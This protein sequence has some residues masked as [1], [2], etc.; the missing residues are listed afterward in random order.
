MA[1]RKL[2]GKALCGGHRYCHDEE[3]L[4]A[5]IIQKNDPK[6]HKKRAFLP[7]FEGNRLSNCLTKD[8]L[9]FTN[10]TMEN[11]NDNDRLMHLKTS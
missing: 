2:G 1:W 5:S 8:G 3:V 9:K 4:P 6:K 7:S 10:R 11:N